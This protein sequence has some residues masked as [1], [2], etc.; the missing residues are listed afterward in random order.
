MRKIIS[1]T[2]RLATKRAA[3]LALK[4]LGLSAWW[5]WPS[6]WAGRKV[7]KRVDIRRH[8]EPVKCSLCDRTS[9]R[10][11]LVGWDDG[12]RTCPRHSLSYIR[13]KS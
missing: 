7:W 2:G 9:R 5:L 1:K 11:I 12:S 4:R 6:L 3:R 13:G 10:S 8:P